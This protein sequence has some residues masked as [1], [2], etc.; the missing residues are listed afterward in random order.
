MGNLAG[1]DANSVQPHAG[2]TV[3]PGGEYE[4]VIASS[5]TKPN[6]KGTGEYLQLELQVVQGPFAGAK[7]TDRLNIV[8][9]SPKAQ[10]IALGTL[11]SICRAVGVLTPQDS[12]DLHNRP[13]VAVVAKT[14]DDRYGERNEVRYYKDR[15]TLAKG[16]P[17][18]DPG[19]PPQPPLFDLPPRGTPGFPPSDDPMPF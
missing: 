3:L 14:L 17:V 12:S 10:E 6:K 16:Q 11:S 8:N 2:F 5:V 4:V 1:F 9:D 13:L 15:T 19:A 18:S 7:L